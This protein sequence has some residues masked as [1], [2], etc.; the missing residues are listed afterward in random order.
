MAIRSF[1]LLLT[2]IMSALAL[3]EKKFCTALNYNQ[4]GTVFATVV[5]YLARSAKAPI[6]VL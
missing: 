4:L 3:P 1:F 2:L 6:I 5:K